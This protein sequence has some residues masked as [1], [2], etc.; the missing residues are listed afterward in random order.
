MAKR[1][2]KSNKHW[3]RTQDQRSVVA[4]SGIML[5]AFAVL[6]YMFGFDA[7]LFVLSFIAAGLVLAIAFLRVVYWIDQGE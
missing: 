5:I 1:K 7:L 6:T 3:P 2:K 4:F